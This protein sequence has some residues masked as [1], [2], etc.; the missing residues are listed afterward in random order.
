MALIGE[1]TVTLRSEIQIPTDYSKTN[2]ITLFVEYN[3]VIQIEE[4]V[5]ASYAATQL[6][7]DLTMIIGDPELLSSVYIFDESP[8]CNYP[9]TVTVTGLPAWTLH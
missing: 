7:P 9:E 6:V 1:Y 2:Y 3:F 8:V 5:I 4:C